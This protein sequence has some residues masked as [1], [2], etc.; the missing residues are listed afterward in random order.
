MASRFKQ[1]IKDL[2]PP[3]LLRALR[4]EAPREKIVFEGPYAS[5]SEA[6]GHATGYDSDA[7]L[8]KVKEALLK[9]KSGEAVYERDSVLFHEKKYSYPLLAGL[10]R[11]AAA[12]E[13]R[14]HV[15]DFGGSLGSS[16]YQNRGF[17]ASL[18]QLKWSVVEQEKF[19][20]CGREHFQDQELRF[21]GDIDQC[22]NRE[23]PDV[24]LLSGVLQY[25][26]D[27]SALLEYAGRLDFK[28]ILVDRTPFAD[29]R[30]DILTVEVVP[31]SIYEASMPFWIFKSH[32]IH[33]A[34][35][36]RYSLAA[37]FDA[38]DGV[39]EYGDVKIYFKGL[40]FEKKT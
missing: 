30:E 1:A 25:L 13:G 4:R 40:L 14:L 28:H 33:D 16:Y 24:L 29:V 21:Y 3:A 8:S 36:E 37:E 20:A 22:L 27:P 12:N 26:Q 5:W 39:M 6:A 7:I 15:L 17:L 18:K 2:I 31:A 35:K 9:V 10:L 23:K 19:V 32:K 38:L 34:L 11:A